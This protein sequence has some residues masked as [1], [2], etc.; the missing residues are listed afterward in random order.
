MTG[1]GTENAPAERVGS[2]DGEA[3]VAELRYPGGVAEFPILPSTSGASSI[4]LSSLTKQTGLTSLDYGFVN[5]AAT[6]SAIT[7]IDGEDRKSVV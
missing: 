5:T 4:D 3:A 2:T 7:Y 1:L 6:R